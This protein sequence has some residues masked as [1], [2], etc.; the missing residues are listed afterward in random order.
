MNISQQSGDLIWIAP[1]GFA[2]RSSKRRIVSPLA[3]RKPSPA[4]RQRSGGGLDHFTIDELH[5]V[6]IG[7]TFHVDGKAV[8]NF[9]DLLQ[10]SLRSPGP[11][12]PVDHSVGHNACAPSRSNSQRPQ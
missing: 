6:W 12:P 7:G 11:C 9:F 3:V 1:R 8:I 10:V 4:R 2:A 5:K